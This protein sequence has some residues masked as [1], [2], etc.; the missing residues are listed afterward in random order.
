MK[1]VE[2]KFKYVSVVSE[3][4]TDEY[5]KDLEDRGFEL[6]KTNMDDDGQIASYLFKTKEKVNEG[7]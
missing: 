3:W 1:V 2:K 7:K 5:R 6:I 4:M